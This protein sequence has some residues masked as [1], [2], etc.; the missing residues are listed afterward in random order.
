MKVGKLFL[1]ISL[2]C[3]R[4]NL[5]LLKK[6]LEKIKIDLKRSQQLSSN[7]QNLINILK[8][9]L[10]Y[11]SDQAT[12]TPEAQNSNRLSKIEI[13]DFFLFISNGDFNLRVPNHVTHLI[14]FK[15]I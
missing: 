4:L 13:V 6:F 3:A 1:K 15:Y 5:S 12:Q 11:F 10:K 7:N 2:I 8:G 14:F 9:L